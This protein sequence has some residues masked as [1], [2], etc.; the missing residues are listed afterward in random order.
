M[1]FLT[2]RM[3]LAH[4]SLTF[5]A[6][7]ANIDAPA[8]LA[9]ARAV[10]AEL[11]SAPEILALSYRLMEFSA[12]VLLLAGLFWL[13]APW[14]VFPF[15]TLFWY[16][17]AAYHTQSLLAPLKYPL[18]NFVADDFSM[19]GL[20]PQL[21]CC[22]YLYKIYIFRVLVMLST[23]T[24]FDASWSP[25]SRKTI[26]EFAHGAALKALQHMRAH[27]KLPHLLLRLWK[28]L[29]VLVIV[30]SV[31]WVIVTII[32]LA[33]P[34][35]PFRCVRRDSLLDRVDSLAIEIH[36]ISSARCLS[37]AG[38][39]A[40]C[41]TKLLKLKTESFPC[42]K[43]A[44]V[45]NTIGPAWAALLHMF[46]D[47]SNTFTFLR[48]RDYMLAGLLALTV[49]IYVGHAV[50]KTKGG[51]QG[52]LRETMTSLECGLF[53]H[54]FL[55]FIRADKGTQ[56]IPALLL[57]IYGLPFAA[58]GWSSALFA[59]GSIGATVFLVI[60]F[61][62]HEYDLGIEQEGLPFDRLLPQSRSNS[63]TS[64]PL[65]AGSVH[66]TGVASGE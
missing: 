46:A 16:L 61:I 50:K 28:V 53:T 34:R 11:G 18:L 7:R 47:I 44:H 51:V 13:V 49:C 62:Y 29:A 10:V 26:E 32:L 42:L 6:T 45:F 14:V 9:A 41:R 24:L 64:P 17:P 12:N 48:N 19:L 5:Q 66:A 27:G 54:D 33:L 40:D 57:Q 8:R 43:L 60:P 36:Q 30:L 1:S 38:A 56:N 37:E 23:I 2:R 39:A 3:F 4:R 15:F 22:R 20:H 25:I 35:S 58:K 21:R 65:D 52:I 31:A 59:A 63:V 55:V